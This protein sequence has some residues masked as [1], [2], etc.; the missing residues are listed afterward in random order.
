[1]KKQKRF[2]RF[3]IHQ[4]IQHILMFTSFI[5]LAITGLP[6]KFHATGW[7]QV[8]V[9][10]FGGFDNM[11]YTHLGAAVIMLIS[12]AYHLIYLL[13]TA[14]I[15]KWSWAALPNLKDAKDLVVSF[16]YLLGV[17]KD[18]PKFDR[19]SYKEKFDYWAVFWGIFIMG[20]SGL[21]LWFPDIA[22]QYFPRWVLSSARVAHSDEAMLAI[23]AIFI[24]HFYNVHLSPSF[25]PGSWVWWHGELTREEMKHEHPIELERLER[26]EN[27]DMDKDKKDNIS[28]PKDDP[29]NIDI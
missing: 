10:L 24:W 5:T 9:N 17:S 11:F 16:K 12:A 28:T 4:R 8:V 25:F 26:E 3:N 7:A 29:K 15:G 21:M 14:L 6:I 1:M 18:K 19:Y 27:P 23:L 20:G 22:A 13:V 2:K